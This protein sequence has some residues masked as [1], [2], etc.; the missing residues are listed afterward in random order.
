M[1]RR[2]LWSLDF[3]TDD[4]GDRRAAGADNQWTLKEFTLRY[5]VSHTRARPRDPGGTAC[6]KGACHAGQCDFLVAAPVKSCENDAALT[7]V[8]A[9][10]RSSLPDK[11]L[12]VSRRHSS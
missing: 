2:R 4:P 7:T 10:Y 8:R 12:S 1:H 6:G 11:L 9:D 3:S 5:H